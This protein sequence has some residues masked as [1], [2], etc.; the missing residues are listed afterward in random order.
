MV[1]AN[2]EPTTTR[3]YLCNTRPSR[4]W[5]MSIYFSKETHH[6][7]V[8]W[9]CVCVCLF[10]CCFVS[11]VDYVH[12]QVWFKN[13]RAK[14]RKKQKAQ[15]PK[16]NGTSSTSAG[17]EQATMSSAGG[18]NEAA[19][20]DGAAHDGSDV[21]DDDVSEGEESPMIDVD[22]ADDREDHPD[23]LAVNVKSGKYYYSCKIYN[24]QQF[25]I[26]TKVSWLFFKR[27]NFL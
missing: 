15:R 10:H 13:R 18:E 21:L 9:T 23:S 11:N 6:N 17:D 5:M 1:K 12:F 3:C 22:D 20:A 25:D 2:D 19:S 27:L 7:I 4:I 14:F 26:C 8:A 24:Y 16:A